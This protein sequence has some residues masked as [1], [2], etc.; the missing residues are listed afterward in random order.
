MIP[1][2]TKYHK[3][4]AEEIDMLIPPAIWNNLSILLSSNVLIPKKKIKVPFAANT[5]IGNKIII[6]IEE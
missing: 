2:R 5:S 6:S 4:P 3:T 1:Q